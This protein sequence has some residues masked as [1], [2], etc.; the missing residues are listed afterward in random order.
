[1]KL[2]PFRR[3]NACLTLGV[4]ISLVGISPLVHAEAIKRDMPACVSEEYLD[5]LITYA[6]KG[7]TKGHSQLYLA[8]KCLTLRAGASVSV[9]SPGIVRAT[10]RYNGTKLFTPAEALR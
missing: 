3:A 1:M 5:E 4:A 2:S 7:D 9:V 8:G 10:V 6:A